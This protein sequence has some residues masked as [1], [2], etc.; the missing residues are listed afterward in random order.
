MFVHNSLKRAMEKIDLR[1]D[2]CEDGGS[3]YGMSELKSRRTGEDWYVEEGKCESVIFVEAAPKS[4]CSGGVGELVQKHGLK[5]GVAEKAGGAVERM[6]QGGDPFR[7]NKCDGVDCFVCG[8]EMPIGCR[9][10]G[11]VCQLECKVCDR[12]YGGRAGR[13]ECERGCGHMK[14]LEDKVGSSPLYGHGELFRQNENFGV[15]V[16]VL[17][18]CCGKASRGMITEAVLIG[19]LENNETMNGRTEWSCTKLCGLWIGVVGEPSV[20]NITDCTFYTN[21]FPLFLHAI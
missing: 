8:N 2:R 5:I 17:A 7:N 12:K 19:E 14:D 18:G 16:S 4:E 20:R 21:L 15:G 9:G 3:C 11:I 1:M 6:L 10:G 13:S